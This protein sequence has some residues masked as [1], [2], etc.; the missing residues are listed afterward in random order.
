M[1][2]TKQVISILF[3]ISLISITI[4]GCN[5]TNNEVIKSEPINLSFYMRAISKDSVTGEL[6]REYN[7]MQDEVNIEFEVFGE[8]Y[9]NVVSIALL[10]DNPPDI[11]ELNGGLQVLELAKGEY[12]IPIDDFVSDDLTKDFYDDVFNQ[13]QFYYA[14]ELY[15]IPERLSYFKLFYNKELFRLSGLD[16]EAPP[17][18]VE[19][20]ISYAEIITES[21]N[22]KYY[23]FGLPLKT[24]TTFERYIDN[25]SVASGLSSQRAF[26]NDEMIF[27]YSKQNIVIESLIKMKEKNVLY[28]DSFSLDVEVNRVLFGEGKFAMMIDGSWM[29]AIYNNEEVVNNQDW[30]VADIPVI[31]VIHDSNGYINYDMGKVISS[32]TEFPEEAWAFIEFLLKNQDRYVKKG[33][34][35]RTVK[36]ANKEIYFP[37]DHIGYVELADIDVVKSESI[38]VNQL[39]NVDR[40]VVNDIYK[41]MFLEE[42]TL[43]EGSK[44]LNDIYNSAL[45]QAIQDDMINPE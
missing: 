38:D 12:I 26:V 29:P 10:S 4:S 32:D 23:G 8:N 15:T 6:V 16:P 14:N 36:T 35:L 24:N 28:P 33:E 25:I 7:E 41:Q 39:L 5:N 44:I 2:L 19:E 11:F 3:I 21:G 45:E 34:P 30:A 13:R 17:Q 42:I 27:D 18:S 20:M 37:E 9:K 1:K 22:G 43:E 31:N 40:S